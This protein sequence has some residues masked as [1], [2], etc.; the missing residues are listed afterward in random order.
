MP[1][2]ADCDHLEWAR[3]QSIADSKFLAQLRGVLEIPAPKRFDYSMNRPLRDNVQI[4]S[5][6]EDD[7][8]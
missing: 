7:D 4:Q 2:T 8:Y 6:R 5:V 1:S 3:A